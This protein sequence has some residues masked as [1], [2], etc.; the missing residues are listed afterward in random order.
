MFRAKRRSVFEPDQMEASLRKHLVWALGLALALATTGG[1]ALAAGTTTQT[2][3]GKA[4][5]S[6]LPE[7][8]RVGVSLKFSETT[9]TTDPS[10]VQPPTKEVRILLDKDFA[11]TTTGLP[12]CTFDEIADKSTADARTACHDAQVGT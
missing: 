7:G 4:I 5:P 12:R 1:I 6:K 8:K 11:I 2:I 3:S 10:G 9:G